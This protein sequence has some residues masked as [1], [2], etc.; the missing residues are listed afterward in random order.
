LITIGEVT[1]AE[2]VR[3]SQLAPPSVENWYLVIVEPPFDAGAVNGTF[4]CR[5][6][7]VG[8]PS[9]GAPGATAVTTAV[10]DDQTVAFGDWPFI[11]VTSTRMNFP[12]KSIAFAMKLAPVAPEISEQ[13][14]AVSVALVQLFH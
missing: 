2:S 4:I 6:P 14:V 7:R 10:G 12:T 9:V 5:S 13:T 11:A 3:S 8:V 1:V